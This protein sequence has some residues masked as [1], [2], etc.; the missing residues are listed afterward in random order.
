MGYTDTISQESDSAT[1]E[2]NSNPAE[3]PPVRRRRSALAWIAVAVALLAVVVLAFATLAGGSSDEPELPSWRDSA[4]AEEI[5]RQAHLDG[6]AR[7]YGGA[8][9]STASNRASQAAEAERYIELQ[10]NRAASNS[11]E[12]STDEFVPGSRRMPL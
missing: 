8:E 10:Q 11:T 3:K 2:P 6:Q 1:R 4:K 12:S 7:T 9:E 5:E